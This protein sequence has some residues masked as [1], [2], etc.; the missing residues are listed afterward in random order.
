MYVIAAWSQTE[1]N[2][3]QDKD[4]KKKTQTKNK[5]TKKPLPKL[6]KNT[7]HFLIC[8]HIWQV[9]WNCY[10]R[11]YTGTSMFVWE[12]KRLALFIKGQMRKKAKSSMQPINTVQ[13]INLFVHH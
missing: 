1:V 2:F 6:K 3:F 8:F 11:G 12:D 4:K 7:K 10:S 9:L 13:S 5:T